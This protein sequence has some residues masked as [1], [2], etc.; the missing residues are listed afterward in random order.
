MPQVT[1]DEARDHLDDLIRTAM[2]GDEV[3]ITKD[4]LPV[5]KLVPFPTSK[6]KPRFGSGKGKIEMANDFDGPLEDFSEYMK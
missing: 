4:S 5:V 3:I 1:L 2:G 6:A